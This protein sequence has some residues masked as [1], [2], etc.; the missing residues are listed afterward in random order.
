[1]RGIDVS[2]HNKSITWNKVKDSIDFAIVRGGYATTVDRY[3]KTN[4]E[5]IIKSGIKLGVDWFSYAY[6]DN[7]AKREAET[8]CDLCDEYKKHITFPLFFDFEYDSKRYADDMGQKITR[9]LIQSMTDTFCDTVKQRGYKAG[10]YANTDYVKNWYGVEYCTKATLGDKYFW[11]AQWGVDRPKHMCDI[12]Q[13]SC[14]GR[15][16]GING[17]VDTNISYINLGN[18]TLEVEFKR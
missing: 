4:I 2:V 17:N 3:A 18:K 6:T 13:N 14:S 5:N 8:M 10:F 12:W 1:M 11:Y 16:D 15:I 7:M 9:K